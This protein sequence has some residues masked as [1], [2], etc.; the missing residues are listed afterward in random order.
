M[1]NNTANFDFS[2]AKVL[3]TGG[4]SGIGAGIAAAY[5]E[6][7]AEVTITGTRASAADYA[8]DLSGF[9]Y[10]QLDVEN[11]AQ[12][13]EVARAQ[14]QLD[15]LVNNAGI[16]LPSLGLDEWDPDNFSRAINIHLVSGFRLA[17]GCRDALQASDFTGG[18]SVVGIASMTSYFGIGLLPGYGAGKTGLLGVIRA[19]AMEWGSLGIR[20]N[21]VAVGLCE[22]RMTSATIANPEWS[23]PTLARTPLGRHGVPED[24]AG[25]VLFLSSAQ[26]S[27]IT[28]QTLPIDGGYTVSG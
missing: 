6:A 11:M 3:V 9:R 24:V 12:I 22:S 23:A 5:L 28:G 2:G 25:A 14:T 26:A 20:A 27:W 8:A 15:V 19:M 16:A 4:T 21:C 17:R 10:L 18:A 13:N 7:G 1:A